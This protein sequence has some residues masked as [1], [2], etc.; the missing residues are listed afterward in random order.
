MARIRTAVGRGFTL[1]ELLVVIGVIAVL[2][3]ILMPSLKRAREMAMQVQCMSNVRQQLTAI[4]M[5]SNDNRGWLPAPHT[6][7]ML[8]YFKTA[9]RTPNLVTMMRP[10]IVTGLIMHCRA[11]NEYTSVDSYDYFSPSEIYGGWNREAEVTDVMTAYMWLMNAASISPGGPP[12]TN[13]NF[14]GVVLH[15]DTRNP[16]RITEARAVDVLISHRDARVYSSS[17]SFL[18]RQ[19]WSEHKY[20]LPVGFGDGHAEWRR[21]EELN[22]NAPRLSFHTPWFY[23]DLFW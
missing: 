5:Y 21:F 17:G 20:G 1:V 8:D 15:G 9:G 19:R 18:F 13:P 14:P 23:M 3:G 7:G 22:M 11:T 10:Y 2:I 6:N 12:P 4:R 16:T